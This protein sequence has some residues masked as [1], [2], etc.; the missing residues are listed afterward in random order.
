MIGALCAAAAV[1]LLGSGVA[2]LRRPAPATRLLA[3]LVGLPNPLVGRLIGALEVGVGAAV[4]LSGGRAACAA[5]AACYLTFALVAVLLTTGSR[6]APCGCFGESDTPTRPLHV[7]VAALACAAA[8]AGVVSP[9][10]ALGG[11][12]GQPTLVMVVGLGQVAVL[13]GLVYLSMTVLPDVLA[14]RE[15]LVAGS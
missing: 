2:K 14:A 1:L 9:V 11:F 10:G 8:V 7:V 4:L 5:L 12:A 3:L 6:P 15:R 13:A